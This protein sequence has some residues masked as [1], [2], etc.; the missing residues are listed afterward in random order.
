MMG[1]LTIKNQMHVLFLDLHYTHKHFNLDLNALLEC[2]VLFWKSWKKKHVQCN[3]ACV[4]DY[5]NKNNHDLK[6]HFKKIS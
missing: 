1:H 3:N 2:K 6:E 4:I 5:L